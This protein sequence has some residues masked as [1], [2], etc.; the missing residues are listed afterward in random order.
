MKSWRELGSEE[1]RELKKVASKGNSSEEHTGVKREGKEIT[2]Q[3][4]RVCQAPGLWAVNK[5]QAVKIQTWQA[6]TGWR[7]SAI[8]R[9][10]NWKRNV[11]EKKDVETNSRQQEG[12]SRFKDDKRK[13]DQETVASSDKDVE[14]KKCHGQRLPRD[15]AVDRHASQAARGRSYRLSLVF[16]GL[17]RFFPS[18]ETSVTRLAR[19]LLVLILMLI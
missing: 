17:Y 11:K 18:L 19:A 8:I 14:S 4:R 7:E 10:G 13:P 3:E 1:S 6:Q 5:K 15:H 2:C 16:I 9:R 12:L